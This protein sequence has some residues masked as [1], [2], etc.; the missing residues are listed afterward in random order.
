MRLLLMV[1]TIALRLRVIAMLLLLVLVILLLLLP[2]PLL[3]P[4]VRG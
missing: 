3:Q 4:L 1:N 2:P